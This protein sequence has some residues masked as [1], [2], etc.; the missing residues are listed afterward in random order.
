[1]F[2]FIFVPLILNYMNNNNYY[3]PIIIFSYKRLEP[4]KKLIKSIKS[5]KDYQLH[6]FYIFSDNFEKK[7]DKSQVNKVRSFCKKVNFKNKKIIF[8]KKNFGLAKNIISG[9]SKIIKIHGRA[10]VL[11]DDLIVGKNFLEF[12]SNSLNKY[13]YKKRVW[14]ITGWSHNLNIFSKN[15]QIYFNRHMTCWGWATWSD[16]W[17]Y[18]EKNPNKIINS[19]KKKK[20][21]EFDQ[22]G[23]YNNWSQIIR[24]KKKLINTWAVFWNATIFNNNGLCL[25][26]TKSLVFNDGLD[27]KSSNMITI[28]WLLK[29][30]KIF[31]F[32]ITKYPNTIK[33]NLFV[34]KYIKKKFSPNPYTRVVKNILKFGFNKFSR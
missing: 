15:E 28:N 6:K 13:K 2:T 31:N 22:Y 10:I 17:K 9:V 23:V 34:K 24:N 29:S 4:L 5:N 11:E 12:M 33:E 19:W 20:I 25:N 1:M 26:P 27:K 8:R 32:K 21:D 18:F 14:H 7:S 3:A 16:R 30:Q